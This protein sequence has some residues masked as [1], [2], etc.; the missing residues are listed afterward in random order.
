MSL[1]LNDTPGRKRTFHG[2]FRDKVIRIFWACSHNLLFLDV[3]SSAQI[4]LQEDLISFLGVIWVQLM[5][6]L[7]C[8]LITSI[9]KEKK[10]KS[11]DYEPIWLISELDREECQTKVNITCSVKTPLIPSS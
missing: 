1:V 9:N 5:L 3:L 2:P 11:I 7:S 10:G 6:K 8:Q 4:A